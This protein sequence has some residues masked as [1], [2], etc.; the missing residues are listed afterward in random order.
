MLV[1]F[2]KAFAMVCMALATSSL[3]GVKSGVPP[4]D[5]CLDVPGLELGDDAFSFFASRMNQ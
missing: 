4:G 3:L 1:C 5:L 2:S